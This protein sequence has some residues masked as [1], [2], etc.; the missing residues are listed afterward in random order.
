MV[1]RTRRLRKDAE[2]LKDD[3]RDFVE[4]GFSHPAVERIVEVIRER[5]VT[6]VVIT[7]AL[8]ALGARMLGRA[9]HL[10]D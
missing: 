3:A 4:E 8:T 7:V 10:G 2:N 5:P 1:S 6:A 9:R